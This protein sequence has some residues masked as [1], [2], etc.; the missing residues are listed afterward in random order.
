MYNKIRDLYESDIYKFDLRPGGESLG[1][2]K[3]SGDYG[4]EKNSRE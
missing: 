1:R 3:Y 2:S 4:D